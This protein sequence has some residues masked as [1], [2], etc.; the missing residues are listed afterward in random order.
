MSPLPKVQISSYFWIPS[1][2]HHRCAYVQIPSVSCLSQMFPGHHYDTHPMSSGASSGQDE[3]YF[4]SPFSHTEWVPSMWPS[5]TFLSFLT[6]AAKRG[7]GQPPPIPKQGL[8][9]QW[10]LQSPARS[11]A[12]MKQPHLLS[13]LFHFSPSPRG[14]SFGCYA[15][16]PSWCEASVKHPVSYFSP[17]LKYLTHGTLWCHKLHFL[18]TEHLCVLLSIPF[19][20]HDQT[21]NDGV[22]Y[23]RQWKEEKAAK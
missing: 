10:A 20:I 1:Y 18:S 8:V 3:S 4:Q 19:K 23:S 6:M 21:I 14:L 12:S 15:M 11:V 22:T 16:N 2:H 5:S 17:T 7:S 13:P 9:P